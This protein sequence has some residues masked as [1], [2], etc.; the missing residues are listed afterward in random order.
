[1]VTA[2]SHALE[3]VQQ[4]DLIY[5]HI[6]QLHGN[7][8]GRGTTTTR[9]LA[10][11]V[12]RIVIIEGQQIVITRLKRICL[13][14]QLQRCTCIRCENDGIP[15]LVPSIEV[16]RDVLSGLLDQPRRSHRGRV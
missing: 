4:L 14:D 8:G 2:G 15:L 13:T 5:A 1:M 10:N 12:D 7:I 11:T 9:K 16:V 6:G 3:A